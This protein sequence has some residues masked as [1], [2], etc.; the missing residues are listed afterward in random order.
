MAIPI[1]KKTLWQNH[2]FVR[3]CVAIHEE[4]LLHLPHDEQAEHEASLAESRATLASLRERA[5][6]LEGPRG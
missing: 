6:R 5:E 4:L 2:D 1:R 3:E